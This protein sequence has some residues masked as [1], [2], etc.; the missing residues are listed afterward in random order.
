MDAF[1]LLRSVGPMLAVVTLVLAALIVAPALLYVIARWRAHREPFPDGQLGLKFALHYFAISAFQLALAGG[2]LFI[3]LLISPGTD[4]GEGYRTALGLLLPAGIV[5][6]IHVAF[7]KRTND[8]ELPGVRRLFL[9]YNVLVTGLLAFFALVLGF[10]ALV[11]KGSSHGLGHLAGAMIVVYGGAWAGTGYKLAQ[12]VL[13]PDLGAGTGGPPHEVVPP[14]GAPT[15]PGVGPTGL[16]SLGG[17][18]YPPI[19]PS[20]S[21]P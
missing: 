9:G 10:Q 13:G 21:Q 14:P 12:L 15:H 6:A 7:L 5:L 17:G 18:A 11:Q 8:R 2:A 4:K 20:R 16:P 3:Y 1:F 19:D